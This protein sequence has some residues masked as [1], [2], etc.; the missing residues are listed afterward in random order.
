[1]WIPQLGWMGVGLFLALAVAM[2][3]YRVFLRLAYVFYGLVILLL[4]AV[5][6]KGRVVMGARRWLALGPFNFQPAELAKIAVMMAV[7]RWFHRDAE[8]EGERLRRGYG[9]LGV[10]VPA[11]LTLLPAA[12]ILRQPDLGTALIVAAIGFTMILFAGVRWRTV[13]LAAGAAVLA[14]VLALPHL[15]PYQRRRLESFL[16]PE[17]DVLGAGYHATQSMIAVG[18]GQ[19]FGKGWGQGTQTLLS[20]L[21]EQ[22][23]DFIFSVWAEER[24]FVGCLLLLGLYYALVGSVLGIAGAARDRFGFLL[25]AGVAAMLFWHTFVNM[26]MVVGL[27]PVVGVTLPL[28]SYGGSSV[29]AT[30]FALGLAANVS[31]RRFVN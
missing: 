6:V 12:L 10:A 27:L 28:L 2:V 4:L 26:G 23:T 16:N 21:P 15:K 11:G 5:L 8:K 9:L 25:G 14:A 3:D 13:A 30:F 22:H 20:F 29:M 7:A 18:S 1:M 17:G 24:G 19:G 31:M